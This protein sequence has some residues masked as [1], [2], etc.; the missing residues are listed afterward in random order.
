MT[1]EEG[2][3]LGW[4]YA[5]LP[6]APPPDLTQ[7]LATA[8]TRSI[9]RLYLA[10]LRSGMRG[11]ELIIRARRANAAPSAPRTFDIEPLI[12]P[13]AEQEPPV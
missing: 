7:A 10:S 6:A 12:P 13:A 8:N 11:R 1:V 9:E 5:N 4:L 2:Q 3:A